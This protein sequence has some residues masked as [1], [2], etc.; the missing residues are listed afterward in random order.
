MGKKNAKS[1]HKKLNKRNLKTWLYAYL[2]V[3]PTVHGVMVLN[4]WGV[5]QSFYYSF[6]EVKG[7]A[8]AKFID[9]NNYTRLF[10]D[11]EVLRSMRNVFVYALITVP[12]GVMFSM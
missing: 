2:F 10:S 12:I 9:L 4:L 7:F 6:H 11:G 1:P 8:E 5:I 3:A